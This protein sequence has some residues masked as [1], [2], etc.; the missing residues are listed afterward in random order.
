MIFNQP[1]ICT[2][3]HPKCFGITFT[4]HCSHNYKQKIKHLWQTTHLPLHFIKH[5]AIINPNHLAIHFYTFQHYSDCKTKIKQFFSHNHYYPT[6]SNATI[7]LINSLPEYTIINGKPVRQFIK[8]KKSFAKMYTYCNQDNKSYKHYF[9]RFFCK[10]KFI[11]KTCV[12]KK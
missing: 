3:N 11:I 7:N 8:R 4:N 6:I 1:E 12:F 2:S 10:I 5:I 9:S